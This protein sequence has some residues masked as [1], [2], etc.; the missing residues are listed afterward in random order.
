M[1]RTLRNPSHLRVAHLKDGE[2]Q[3]LYGPG[4]HS[5]FTLFGLHEFIELDVREALTQV[6][7]TDPLPAQLEGCELVDVAPGEVLILFLNG[8][9]KRVVGAGRYR[10][11]ESAHKV[12][13]LRFNT[14]AA[15]EPLS[16]QD[17]LP[18]ALRDQ[19]EVLVDQA[20]ATLLQEH[21][22]PVRQLTAGRYRIWQQGPWTV[23]DLSLAER[24]LALAA[25][26][27]ITA[28]MV[29]LRV[30]PVAS[31]RVVNALD[32]AQAQE[33]EDLLYTAVQLGL[34]EVVAGRGLEELLADR[35]A[36]SELLLEGARR[37]LP[38]LGVELCSASVKDLILSGD[39]KE[40]FNKVTVARKEAE[41]TSIRRRE[42]VAQTRQL[43]NTAKLLEKNP[44]LLRL[45]EL[46]QLSLLAQQVGTLT[47]VGGDDMVKSLMLSR[48]SD[49]L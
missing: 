34:R 32:W 27:L 12:E 16:E 23:S 19:H 48:G 21:G 31:W 7:P 46:E 41:A 39:V 11:W 15:P 43:A 6:Q 8:E 18:A 2:L 42:E 3:R 13:L 14:L 22:R 25:Q 40:Q 30:K 36:L 38:E 1:L 17:R 33:P 9:A 10:R 49:G 26:D 44:V 24:E 45:K 28:D 37:H 5:V 4:Q 35:H 47:L 29:P 20:T